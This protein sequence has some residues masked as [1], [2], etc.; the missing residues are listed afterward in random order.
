MFSVKALGTGQRRQYRKSHYP[1]KDIMAAEIKTALDTLQA[2]LETDFPT[3]GEVDPARLAIAA[4]LL[5][6]A[7]AGLRQALCL[8]QD[9]E[10]GNRDPMQQDR[11]PPSH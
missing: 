5:N 2:A 9:E 11:K 3:H 6:P 4:Q 1:R 7:I 10:G 8:L